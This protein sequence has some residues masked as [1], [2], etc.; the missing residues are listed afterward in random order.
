MKTS[1]YKRG[2]VLRKKEID[3]TKCILNFFCLLQYSTW[4]HSFDALSKNLQCKIVVK[5][6][7][8]L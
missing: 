4:A 6:K 8:H 2:K 5:K 3:N 1:K 7:T